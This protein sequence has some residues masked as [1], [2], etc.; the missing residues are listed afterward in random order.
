M[1]HISYTDTHTTH[2]LRIRR[3]LDATHLL[4]RHTHHP[5][6]KDKEGVRPL[7]YPQIDLTE[8]IITE[9]VLRGFYMTVNRT[10]F[11]DVSLRLVHI[12]SDMES[13]PAHHRVYNITF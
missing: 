12:S 2:M 10:P 13:S 4:H 8:H 1:P 11:K 5:Y 3:G 6:A 7:H 9:T